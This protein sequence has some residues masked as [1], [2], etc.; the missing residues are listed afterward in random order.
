MA[1][2]VREITHEEFVEV[3]R[4][5]DEANRLM[6]QSK[7]HHLTLVEKLK[8]QAQAKAL[9]EQAANVGRRP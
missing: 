8:L 3:C 9:R 7:G 5:R 4:L 6:M 1:D 2:D